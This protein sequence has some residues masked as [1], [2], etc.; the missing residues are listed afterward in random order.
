MWSENI[1]VLL[2]K[3][4]INSTTKRVER[5]QQVK[6]ISLELEMKQKE[7]ESAHVSVSACVHVCMRE[8]LK[9]MN[10]R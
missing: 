7:T 6:S 8:V 1:T 2:I 10:P 4:G 9:D 3:R 5:K